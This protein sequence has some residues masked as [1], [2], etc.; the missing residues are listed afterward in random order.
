M[1]TAKIFENIKFNH[2][3]NTAQILKVIENNEIKTVVDAVAVVCCCCAC[4][5]VVIVDDIIEALAKKEGFKNLLNALDYKTAV[6]NS[7]SDLIEI[8]KNEYEEFDEE[9]Q[10]F[11]PFTRMNDLFTD[12]IDFN[13]PN[14]DF[15]QDSENYVE[16]I[17]NIL[18]T[19][20]FILINEP[21]ETLE[22]VFKFDAFNIKF[23]YY[24]LFNKFDYNNL[25]NSVL[26]DFKKFILLNSVDRIND[27]KKLYY[28][29]PI[30]QIKIFIGEIKDLEHDFNEENKLSQIVRMVENIEDFKP[31][32]LI[33]YYEDKL[34]D[35]EEAETFDEVKKTIESC[36]KVFDLIENYEIPHMFNTINEI[37]FGCMYFKCLNTVLTG[38]EDFYTYKPL[39]NIF[40]NMDVEEFKAFLNNDDN[41]KTIFSFDN[42]ELIGETK[43]DT[44]ENFE[45]V[46]NTFKN[47]VVR[48]A[49]GQN[50][51]ITWSENSPVQIAKFY[52]YCCEYV[53][54]IKKFNVDLNEFG[55]EIVKMLTQIYTVFIY[56]KSH[57]KGFEVVELAEQVFDLLKSYCS[58][59]IKKQ[60]EK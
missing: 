3:E 16:Y 29:A 42:V 11:K 37:K 56:V 57:V 4:S 12:F 55:F 7:L 33:D 40:N 49:C 14:G 10:E 6:K 31:S 19:I 53:N 15:L 28:N 41:F 36:K 27:F 26:P 44:M 52:R 34:E 9:D 17:I 47:F 20:N 23:I 1:T 22:K 60:F 45:L 24:I 35:F 30:E 50:N 2:D 58:D 51:K 48:V 25:F 39:L 21:I 46:F 8:D 13:K 32:V 59:C 43:E 5:N 18:M 54:D 38:C